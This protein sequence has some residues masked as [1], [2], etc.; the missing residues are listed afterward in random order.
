[1]NRALNFAHRKGVTWWHPG[2]QQR[3]HLPTRAPTPRAPTTP[4]A[5]STTAPSTTRTAST[6]RSRART[7]SVSR[8]SARRSA[9]PTTPTGPPT[10]RPVSSRSRR[11]VAGSATASARPPTAPTATSSCPRHPLNVLQADGPVDANGNI[12]PR[13]RG[14]RRHQGLRHGQGQAGLRLLPVPPGHLDGVTA[15][16]RRRRAR[17]VGARQP[18]G[19]VRLRAGPRRGARHPHG[20]R[21]R[22]RLPRGWRCSRYAEWAASRRV[23]RPCAGTA[24]LQRR[25]TATASSTPWASSAA[26]RPRGHR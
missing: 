10:S 6:C 13:R 21:D 25:S 11:P 4:A 7:S 16:R 8:R 3:G 2:Q 15:R 19:Q 5:P 14:P 1:M 22:P 18:A 23:R 12:T 24:G 26:A 20:H 17:R 9:R